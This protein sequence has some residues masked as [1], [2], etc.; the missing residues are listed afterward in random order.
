[1]NVTTM[2]QCLATKQACKELNLTEQSNLSK[3]NVI[4]ARLKNNQH[5]LIHQ[6][7]TAIQENKPQYA[8]LEIPKVSRQKILASLKKQFSNQYY[9]NYEIYNTKDF[10]LSQGRMFTLVILSKI[11]LEQPNMPFRTGENGL[12]VNSIMNK[13]VAS[14]YYIYEEFFSY[15]SQFI[16]SG[17]KRIG[18][19][20]IDN[21][22]SLSQ[23]R[24]VYSSSHKSCSLQST[25]GGWGAKT[26]IYETEFGYRILTPQECFKLQGIE[27]KDLR[28]SDSKKYLLINNSM[29][30]PVIKSALMNI[31]T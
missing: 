20:K 3:T 8:V 16:S 18:V 7:F 30:Y 5:E 23:C 21:D 22:I 26:G 19:I 29:C 1:M 9:I 15:P 11:G 12:G 10:Q 2:S 25:S 17:V 27:Y 28:A 4:Q 13:H 24:R 14:K 6:V 31:I